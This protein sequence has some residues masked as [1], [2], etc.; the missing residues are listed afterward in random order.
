MAGHNLGAE[1]VN[2]SCLMGMERG[3]HIRR[4]L[5]SPTNFGSA[6]NF[7]NHVGYLCE[8]FNP[9]LPGFGPRFTVA[10]PL[11]PGGV[12]NN[13]IDLHKVGVFI[14]TREPEKD[15]LIVDCKNLE[16]I[17]WMYDQTPFRS[18]AFLIADAKSQENRFLALPKD[19]LGFPKN[20]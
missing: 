17:T 2:Y 10:L 3:S 6:S 12:R 11:T 15:Y 18:V 7:L 19:V 8:S 14:N 5:L 1:L 9:D 16:K 20:G 4:G 13:R